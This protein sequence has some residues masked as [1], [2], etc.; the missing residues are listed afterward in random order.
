MTINTID[1]LLRLLREDED[2]RT[3]VRRELLT[4]E[5]L[6][7]PERFAKYAE[8]TDQRLSG[9]EDNLA[10]LSGDVQ[11]LDRGFTR[12]SRDFG[13]FRGQYARHTVERNATDIAIELDESRAL[14]IDENAVRVLSRDDLHTLAREYGTD[15]LAPIPR[16]ARR[17]FYGADLV[18]E[19]RRE[20][21]DSC[22]IA[23]EASYT[24]NT[25][26]T[27]RVVNNVDLLT[28]FTGKDAWAVIAGVRVDRHIQPIIDSGDVLFYQLEERDVQPDE[29]E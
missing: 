3:A 27:T 13:R 22:Y 6:K 10:S 26:E 21:G 17:R 28:K 9:I 5:L 24:C 2:V 25:R 11:R 4:E 19:V 7:L 12:L 20:G 23:V 29:P 16:S 1:D 8:I 14:G 18:M 15:R